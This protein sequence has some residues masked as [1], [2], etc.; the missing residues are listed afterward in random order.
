MKFQMIEFKRETNEIEHSARVEEICDFCGV[1][2]P[3]LSGDIHT[4]SFRNLTL[5]DETKW[6]ELRDIIEDILEGF[7][8]KID[9]G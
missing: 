2:D 1:E 9:W 6:L 4:W 3:S 8:V 7:G 5:D